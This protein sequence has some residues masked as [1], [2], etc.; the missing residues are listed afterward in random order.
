MVAVSKAIGMAITYFTKLA[1]KTENLFLIKN[2]VNWLARQYNLHVKV[3]RLNN[4]MNQIK[5]IDEYN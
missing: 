3:V 5:T 4:K 1:K 2:L